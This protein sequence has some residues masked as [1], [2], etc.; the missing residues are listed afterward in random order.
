MA[1][2]GSTNITRNVSGLAEQPFGQGEAGLLI[3]VW[4]VSGAGATTNPD[5]VAI[6]P[7]F[8]TD[9]RMV[10]AQQSSTNNLTTNANT[11]VTL[12]LT[13]TMATNVNFDVWL[14]GRR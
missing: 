5:T 11:N 13:A 6:T 10:Q 8:I 9:I 14:I 4:R 2:L 3:E 1:T 7:F 12:T